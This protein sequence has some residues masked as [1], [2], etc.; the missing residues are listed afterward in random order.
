MMMSRAVTLPPMSTRPGRLYSTLLVP[1]SLPLPIR[2]SCAARQEIVTVRLGGEAFA[3][4][5]K[6]M[7]FTMKRCARQG[8]ISPASQGQTSTVSL[9]ECLPEPDVKLR[10]PQIP[11]GQ[12]R[13]QA[14]MLQAVECR[15]L[16]DDLLRLAA[17]RD[18][19]RWPTDAC[20][21]LKWA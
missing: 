13:W 3:R 10:I 19:E 2:M 1:V 18:S 11:T 16:G 17:K 21:S 14:A 12:K 6:L 5:Q 8:L 20:L 4:Q 9:S 7:L 15:L